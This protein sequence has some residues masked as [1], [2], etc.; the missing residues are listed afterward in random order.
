MV[1]SNGTMHD[2]VKVAVVQAEVSQATN[3]CATTNSLLC[4]SLPGLIWS[5]G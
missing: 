5:W 2:G 4:S 1:A 3:I